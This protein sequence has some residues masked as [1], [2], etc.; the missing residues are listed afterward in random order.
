MENIRYKETWKLCKCGSKIFY[1]MYEPVNIPEM[2][3]KCQEIADMKQSKLHEFT[4]EQ[5]KIEYFGSDE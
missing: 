2:C 3:S 1:N 5:K 4:G